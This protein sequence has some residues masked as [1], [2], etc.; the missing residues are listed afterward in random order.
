[1]ASNEELL[2]FEKSRNQLL[3][4]TAQK[5][6]LALQANTMEAALEELK[7]S[8]EKKVYKA[9]GNILILSDAKTVEK[10]ITEQKETTD[11]RLKS[12]TKQE[13]NLIEKLNKLRAKIEKTTQPSLEEKA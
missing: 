2:D 3:T 7:K 10:E 11:L 9:I 13:E 4:V 8:K 5:Q 12:L 6:Q 1:M